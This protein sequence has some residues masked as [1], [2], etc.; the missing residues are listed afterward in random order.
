MHLLGP[1][2]FGGSHGY[3]GVSGIRDEYDLIVIG[4]SNPIKTDQRNPHMLI[5]TAKNEAGS[6]SKK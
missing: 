3:V 4:S 5:I 2:K 1:F 6:L